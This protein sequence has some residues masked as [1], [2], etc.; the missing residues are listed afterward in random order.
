MAKKTYDFEEI[1]SAYV[2]CFASEIHE[3]DKLIDELGYNWIERPVVVL[4]GSGKAGKS[5]LLNRL[6]GVDFC[7]LSNYTTLCPLMVE[8]VSDST[9]DVSFVDVSMDNE[10][11]DYRRCED[12]S[13]VEA[14]ARNMVQTY[15]SE[16]TLISDKPIHIRIT[17]KSGLVMKFLELPG[18]AY[19]DSRNVEFDIHSKTSDIVKMYLRNSNFIIVVVVPAAEEFTN[20]ESL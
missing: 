19:I 2:N 13:K 10:F 9:V 14:L 3:I 17:Q 12:F 16:S 1:N 8:M 4:I 6:T 7:G 15:N 20:S 11:I 5:A 18:I